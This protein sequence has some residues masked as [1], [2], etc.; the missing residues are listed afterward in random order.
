MHYHF[1]KHYISS[2]YSIALPR[3]KSHFNIFLMYKSSLLTIILFTGFFCSQKAISQKTVDVLSV[4]GK[5]AYTHIDTAGTSVLASGRY[6]T[7][8]GKTLQISHDPFGIAVSPD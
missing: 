1:V 3:L 6:V 7:P 2:M 5:T 8:A 4:P